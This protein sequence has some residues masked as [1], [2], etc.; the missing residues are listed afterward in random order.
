[1]YV[2][3]GLIAAGLALSTV[4]CATGWHWARRRS[5]SREFGLE[6]IAR[7]TSLEQLKSAVEGLAPGCC[8]SFQS[9]GE[10][11]GSV[12][13]DIG[14]DYAWAIPIRDSHNQIVGEIAWRNRME[15][16]CGERLANLAGSAIERLTLEQRWRENAIHMELAEKAAGFGTWEVDWATNTIK[17]SQGTVALTWGAQAGSGGSVRMTMEEFLDR[18]EP[19]YRERIIAEGQKTLAGE[20][21]SQSEFRMLLPDGS[22]RWQ[23][24]RGR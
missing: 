3:L 5:G 6:T 12:T 10:N 13:S 17:I 19:E 24:S 16:K 15:S 2:V 11:E 14:P 18:I 1:M 23:R 21:D 22:V 4:V 8:C 20:Q 9:P 7:A